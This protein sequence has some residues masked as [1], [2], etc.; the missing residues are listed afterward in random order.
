MSVL[1]SRRRVAGRKLCVVLRLDIVTSD[2][3]NENLLV[4]EIGQ[5]VR[6]FGQLSLRLNGEVIICI[7]CSE[8]KMHKGLLLQRGG[9]LVESVLK[10]VFV[11]SFHSHFLFYIRLQMF[12]YNTRK[13]TIK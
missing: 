2:I 6:S 11:G 3:F 4:S 13:G 12:A 9:L 10:H 8:C 7:I 5:H 1:A